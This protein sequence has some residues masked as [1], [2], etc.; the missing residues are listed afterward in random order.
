MEYVFQ[1]NEQI[2]DQIKDI[3]SVYWGDRMINPTFDLDFLSVLSA[4]Y[5]YF[6]INLYGYINE[7]NSNNKIKLQL[8]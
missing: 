5:P 6:G 7:Q 1:Q 4:M 3:K 2:I 8:H